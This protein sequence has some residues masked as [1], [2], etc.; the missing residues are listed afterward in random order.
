MESI[1]KFEAPGMKIDSR[2]T[3]L[4]ITFISSSSTLQA[5]TASKMIKYLDC[6]V[7][8]LLRASDAKRSSL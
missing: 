4:S 7:F 3:W 5:F 2:K 1:E 8:H 6:S